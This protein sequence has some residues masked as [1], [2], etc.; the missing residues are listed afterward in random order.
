[1]E[2][3]TIYHNP[4]C[5][6]SRNV[7]AM[8]R[9]SGIEPDIIYYLE[10][11]PSREKIVQLL[12]DMKISVREL[13]RQ[14]DTPYD[15]LDLDNKKWSDAQLID[16]IVQHPILMNR[17]IVITHLGTKLCRPSESVLDI[18]PTPQLS[19]FIKEDGEVVIDKEGNRVR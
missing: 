10:T 3:I 18:L 4:K 2:Q 19:P 17:P 12:R 11:P 6:T 7:L 16:F 1:V 9:N 15:E 14:K 5:G 8:I 13:L